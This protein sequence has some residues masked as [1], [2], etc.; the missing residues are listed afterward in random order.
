MAQPYAPSEKQTE[1]FKLLCGPATNILLRG[2]ARSGKTVQIIRFLVL[3]ALAASG[4]THAI[5]R[6]TF[7]STRTSLV[8]GTV[9]L[10]MEMCFPK[11]G[12]K[13]NKSEWFHEF[14]NG[15]RFYYGGLDSKE[16]T[17]KIL[18]QEHAS[19]FLNECSGISYIGRNKAITR[20]SQHAIIDQPGHISLGQRLRLKMI[21][22]C[23]P[24]PMGHWTY[25]MFM[26]GVEPTSKMP[27]A[28]PEDY[29]TLQINPVHNLQNLDP[30]TIKNLESMPEDQKQ[31]FLYGEFQSNAVGAL[32][33]YENLLRIEAPENDAEVKAL[34]D[35]MKRIVVAVDPSGCSGAEDL[36]SDEIGI[37]VCG[38]GYD[39]IGYVLEDLSGRFSPEGW[40]RVAVN[41]YD[42]WEADFIVGEQNY[43]GDM[44]RSTVQAS[45]R[46]VPFKKV[47]ASRGKHVRAEPVSTLYAKGMV[48]HAGVFKE[49]EAQMMSFTSSGY[50]GDRSPDRADA[51]I[52]G[53]TELMLD[54]RQGEASVSIMNHVM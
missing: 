18:G 9:P 51:M 16:R 28:H 31:R 41:A 30:Q 25:P 21:Q 15:S 44:V 54:G 52:W 32:W 22:D 40:G 11:V 23:N 43:G 26:L 48:K 24:P 42:K 34:L 20:L 8:N 12:L 37:M 29:A 4:S 39:G 47:T 19:I 6:H 1:G 45:R 46:N 36:R 53:F 35:K 13:L 14:P 50:Q 5:F 3:R 7:H 38:L 17:D 2:G 10:V 49:L 27:H 33:A